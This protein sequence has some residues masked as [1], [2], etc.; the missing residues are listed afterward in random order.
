MKL[1]VATEISEIPVSAAHLGTL[2]GA[3]PVVFNF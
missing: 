2:Q 3:E 1:G